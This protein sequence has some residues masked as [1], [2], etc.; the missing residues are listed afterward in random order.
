MGQFQPCIETVVLAGGINRIPLFEGYQ[1]GYKALLPIAG[2]P[3]ICYTLQAL[4][5]TPQLGRVCI[6]GPEAELRPVV[7]EGYDFV[8]GG[9][10]LMESI[11]NGLNHVAGSSQVLVATADLPLIDPQAIADFLTACAQNETVYPENLFISVVPRQCYTGAYAQFTKGFNRFRDIAVC[12][13]N[14][15]LADPAIV[16]NTAA[17]GRMN[18]IYQAR[19]SPITS[20]LAIGMRV[21]LS[22]VLGVHLL[23]L[24]TL[25]QMARIVSRRFG[26]GF[27]PVLLEHPEVTID[28]DEPADYRFVLDQLASRS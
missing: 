20:A 3:S 22:Y 16:R 5:A 4:A 24:L 18:A 14:L 12:H 27:V 23:H 21:G 9:E 19:K 6:V 10:T 15:L 8:P 2:K 28:I 17:T 26:I 25:A 7:G 11:F 1:P 13:G